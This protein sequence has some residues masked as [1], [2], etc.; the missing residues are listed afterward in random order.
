MINVMLDL[1]TMG[2]ATDTVVTSI[3]A[4]KFDADGYEDNYFHKKLKIGEMLNRGFSITAST[5]EWW[6]NQPKES[7]EETLSEGE[8]LLKVLKEFNRWL[9]DDIDNIKIWSNGS[10]FDNAIMSS[11][12]K[13]LNGNTPWKFWNTRC[14][15]TIC[16]FNPQVNKYYWECYNKQAKTSHI[17]YEDCLKQITILQQINN[18]FNLKIIF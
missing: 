2:T 1:E 11:L 7:L 14:Y 15:R 12:Y 10:D 9:G 18:K 17:G 16:N 6:L 8:S 13:K 4:V 3:S 5:L